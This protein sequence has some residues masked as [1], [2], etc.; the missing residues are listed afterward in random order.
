VEEETVHNG[1][2]LLNISYNPTCPGI[3]KGVSFD[4]EKLEKIVIGQFL[5]RTES[6]FPKIRRLAAEGKIDRSAQIY[7]TLPGRKAQVNATK[8]LTKLIQKNNQ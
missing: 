2:V 6:I 4:K 1:D 3:G 5:Q 7:R 8:S